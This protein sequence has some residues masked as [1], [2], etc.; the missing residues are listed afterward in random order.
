MGELWN[1][2]SSPEFISCI[3][4]GIILP[5]TVICLK[6][7]FDSDPLNLDKNLIDNAG[8][9]SGSCEFIDLSETAGSGE[10]IDLPGG[11]SASSS[12]PFCD[13]AA[14]LNQSIYNENFV[15]DNSLINNT[16][17]ARQNSWEVW[18]FLIKNPSEVDTLS[19]SS[20]VDSVVDSV[21]SSS[22][23]LIWDI[24]I[25]NPSFLHIVI[26]GVVCFVIKCIKILW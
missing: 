7:D 22:S 15:L 16:L 25:N 23:P 11:S 14:S 4:I 21:I 2:I 8:S 18:D 9:S 5:I 13:P 12:D 20:S 19:S 3:F 10:F 1:I 6:R 24:L 17:S 26:G